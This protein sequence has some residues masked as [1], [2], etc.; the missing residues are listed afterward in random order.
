MWFISLVFCCFVVDCIYR[1]FV[2]LECQQAKKG[3]II[4]SV[5]HQSNKKWFMAESVLTSITLWW[6]FKMEW[7][8]HL[9]EKR[10]EKFMSS[11]VRR[12]WEKHWVPFVYWYI[13]YLLSLPGYPDSWGIQREVSK[14]AEDMGRATTS[15]LVPSLP[16]HVCRCVFVVPARTADGTARIMSLL[17][18]VSVIVS[19]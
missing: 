13:N 11:F 8:E 6:G 3:V 12:S 10:A 19:A 4:E 15:V 16:A 14:A 9:K 17:L 5:L 2:L 1:V 18:N 7:F